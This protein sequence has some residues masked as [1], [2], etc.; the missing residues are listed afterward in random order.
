MKITLGKLVETRQI[1]SQLAMEKMPVFAAYG[2]NKNIQKTD[3]EFKNFESGRKIILEKYFENEVCKDQA[4]ADK[5]FNE[6]V[7]IEVEIEPFKMD[8]EQFGKIEIEPA[9][10][11]NIMWLFK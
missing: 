7:S 2:L 6:L 10:L 1:L 8:A 9:A 11:F 4:A 5:E 3:E